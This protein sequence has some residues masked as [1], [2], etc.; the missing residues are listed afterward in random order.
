VNGPWPLQWTKN[1]QPIPGATGTSYTTDV[2]TA[3]MNQDPAFGIKLGT[4]LRFERSHP[5]AIAGVCSRSFGDALER[6][7]R[8]NN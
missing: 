7:A 8:Y 3:E 4:E 1:G 2:I 5:V 6:L